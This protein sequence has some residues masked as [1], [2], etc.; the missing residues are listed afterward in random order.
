MRQSI[1]YAD[2]RDDLPQSDFAKRLAELRIARTFEAA[3]NNERSAPPQVQT[4]AREKSMVEQERPYPAPRPSPAIAADVDAEAFN[5][6][7]ETE[8]Q[9]ATPTNA[10]TP[11][12]GETLM[13]EDTK[14]RPAETLR[15]GS[16]KAAIWRNESER[17]A[18]H[19]VT[20][21]RTYKDQEGNFHDTSS[22]RAQ[23]ML[24]V[25]ELARQAHHHTN[26]LDREA[27]KEQRQAQEQQAPAQNQDQS[28]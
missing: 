2:T 28:R 24:G 19:S 22:F 6:R 16:L 11:N 17:G 12:Q 15:E 5:A 26:D 1:T 20:L 3:N 25:A 10:N 9:R 21:A 13:S 23:D 7:W 18:Y 4:H 14:N 27:F 8:R